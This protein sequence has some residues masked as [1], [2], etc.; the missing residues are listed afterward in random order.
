MD[1][2]FSIVRNH[3]NKFFKKKSE[4]N[5]KFHDSF[6]DPFNFQNSKIKFYRPI[7]TKNFK[8]LRAFRNHSLKISSKK[9]KIRWKRKDFQ[10]STQDFL[11]HSSALL[12]FKIQYEVPSLCSIKV[13]SPLF[14][15][16]FSQVD[17]ISHGSKCSSKVFE[18]RPRPLKRDLLW[19]N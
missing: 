3:L 4:S 6:C 1:R 8:Y 15:R 11:H 9:G 18:S 19:R 14:L 2:K 5:T 10:R 16:H 17:G 7:V 12:T 13:S